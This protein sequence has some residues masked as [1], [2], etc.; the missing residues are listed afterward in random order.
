MSDILDTV[1]EGEINLEDDELNAGLDVESGTSNILTEDQEEEITRYLQTEIK[2]VEESGKR[3]DFLKRVD[4]WRRQR[5]AQPKDKI[6]NY[7]WKG[8]SNVTVPL[9]L[10]NANGIFALLK[11]NLSRRIPF[12][13]VETDDPNLKDQAAA[14]EKLI[15]VYTESRQHMSLR[16]KNNTILYDMASLG[17]QFVKIPWTVD[18][19]NFKRRGADGNLETVSK[20]VK[21]SPDLIPI[22]M[23]DFLT[24]AYWGADIQRA[25]WISHK[26]HLLKHE[27][28]QREAKGIF[29]NVDRVF[30]TP[31]DDID[32]NREK[33]LKRSGI[34]HNQ[35]GDSTV[36]DIHEVYLYWD[37]D[38]DGIVEDL[39]IWFEPITG[40]IL[41]V[42]YNDLGIRPIVRIPYFEIPGELYAMG[43]GWMTENLQDEIDTLHNMRIDGTHV[44]MLQMFVSR[45]G[46]GLGPNEEFF[47][48]KHIMLD[49]PVNDFQVVKFPDLGYGT[50]QAELMS[51]EYADRATGSADA[52]M[53]F[54][55]KSAGTRATSSGTQ[56]LAQQGSRVFNAISESVEDAYSEIGQIIVFQ[57]IKNKNLFEDDINKLVPEGM[58]DSLK[59]VLKMKVEDIPGT[60]KFKVKTTDAEKTEDV[61]R[62]SILTLFQ[63]Y[64]TGG[65]K[66]L[67]LA[68]MIFSP[69]A[70]LPQEV[71]DVAVKFY[72]GGTKLLDEIMEFFG[73]DDRSDFLP[74][75]KNLEYMMETIDSMKD[76]Q[77]RSI[78]A[79][80][81]NGERNGQN[82]NQNNQ[83][84]QGVGSQQALEPGASINRGPGRG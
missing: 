24:Q 38:G 49:D 65:E 6:K 79:Q 82:Q 52:M 13:Q 18:E 84:Q 43:T 51:K 73:E 5:E 46:S 62:Q 39:I 8:A 55:S 42:E 47:P 80:I 15:E 69:Q 45:R 34:E 64:I 32:E 19:W 22:R 76:N 27:L 16:K 31:G 28:I 25:P 35:Q 11:S 66:L 9:A 54:E 53:G 83:Q 4:K 41:R 77:L 71:K 21:N 2:D 63:L 26:I 78:K 57:I 1:I 60:F 44:S 70:N 33:E 50:L 72:I 20:K 67:Q 56:F 29:S 36:Y 74:Y 61:R 12:W 68:G 7:P 10:T 40:T 3:V 59:E 48:L 17:T 14:L 30:E 23:E 37:T 58:I 81:S 75:I